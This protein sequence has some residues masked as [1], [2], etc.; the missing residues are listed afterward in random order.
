MG[1]PPITTTTIFP[2]PPQSQAQ[3]H[4][5]KG[6]RHVDS[7]RSA[8]SRFAF[9][10]QSFVRVTLVCYLV[11]FLHVGQF[12]RHLMKISVLKKVSWENCGVFLYITAHSAPEPL[13]ACAKGS[14]RGRV[15]SC[16]AGI[17]FLHGI[18]RRD[19]VSHSRGSLDS[20]EREHP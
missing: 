18:S 14:S 13:D 16:Q 5:L 8:P 1:T 6:S 2:R 15:N 4:Q 10:P 11:Q 20:P 19:R 17:E 9:L 3:L 12:Q 7:G